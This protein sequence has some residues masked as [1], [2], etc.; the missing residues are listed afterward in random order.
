M[1]ILTVYKWILLFKCVANKTKEYLG[2]RP[3]ALMVGTLIH[4]S[5][6][7]ASMSIAVN[8]CSS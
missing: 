2:L 5:I 1:A 7:D 8:C 6:G 4:V 3:N